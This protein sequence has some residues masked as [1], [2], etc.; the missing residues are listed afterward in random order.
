MA[1]DIF[2]VAELLP[3]YLWPMIRISAFVIAV[4]A[5]GGAF[6]PRRIRAILALVL[7]L[8]IAP[9]AATDAPPEVI[10]SLSAALLVMQEVL[11]GI[12][13]GFTVQLVFDAI[14]LGAQTVSMSMG[15]GFA[16]F[17][18]RVS[19]VNIPVIGQMYLMLAMLLFLS[20][21][22]HL[23]LIRL[24][25]ESFSTAPVGTSFLAL[26]DLEGVLTFS[27][28]LFVGAMRIALPAIATLLIVNLAFGVMSRAAPSM[29]LFAVGFPI[30][31]LLGFLTLYATVGGLA[32]VF[33]TSFPLALESL[34]ALIGGFR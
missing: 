21:D 20:A 3:M 22:G 29:N 17:L 1:L 26:G 11:L 25:A 23:Q 33:S 14:V 4:P 8:A 24:L 13:M 18:D 15:L 7:T 6:V 19:G 16:V 27:S 10:F 31:M 9:S 5:I 32:Q 30:S 2:A 12:L 34:S 28:Q